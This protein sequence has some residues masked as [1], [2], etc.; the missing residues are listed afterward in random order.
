MKT[1]IRQ[2][3]MSVRKSTRICFIAFCA[4][5]ILASSCADA[6]TICQFDTKN[7]R[8]NPFGMRSY[9]TIISETPRV[10]RFIYDAFGT[11]SNA[12]AAKRELDIASSV[13]VARKILRTNVRAYSLLVGEAG[14]MREFI[15]IW[16]RG[17]LCEPA[18][19]FDMERA[20]DKNR[21]KLSFK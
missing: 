9:I 10:T 4:Y 1:G 16:D 14:D 2:E 5:V 17:L 11:G 13:A 7:G 3:F 12:G 8:P 20:N 15:A 19:A 6:A 18:S 21:K